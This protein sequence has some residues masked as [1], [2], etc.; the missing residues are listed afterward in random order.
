MTAARVLVVSIKFPTNW[1]GLLLRR[2][3]RGPT[4]NQF[5]FCDRRRAGAFGEITM[6]KTVL[7]I[8]TSAVLAVATLAPTTA[9][10]RAAVAAWVR[11]RRRPRG[12]RLIGGAIASGPAYAYPRSL[13]IR[14]PAT[15]RMACVAAL[16]C[17]R[18]WPP[19]RVRYATLPHR[20]TRCRIR[21]QDCASPMAPPQELR[22]SSRGMPSC[23]IFRA[24]RTRRETYPCAARCRPASPASEQLVAARAR[25][26]IASRT[27]LHAELRSIAASRGA[28]EAS[29]PAASRAIELARTSRRS[30]ELGSPVWR[31]ERGRATSDRVRAV[32][33]EGRTRD[34]ALGLGHS[35]GIGEPS[36]ALNIRHV[37][38]SRDDASSGHADRDLSV[39][40]RAGR[41]LSFS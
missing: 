12:R 31:L 16:S 27:R 32:P 39:L 3:R 5:H 35:R 33:R 28:R 18:L 15:S 21:R 26:Q 2:A 22:F 38:A 9:D 24:A 30:H 11:H 36:S 41:I 8:A 1:P 10:A 37:L 7:A 40:I 34:E 4:L 14:L 13:L 20:P 23:S 6:K 25:P 17:R 19:Q 29:C